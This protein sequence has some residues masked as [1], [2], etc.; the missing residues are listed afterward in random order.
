MA[1][2]QTAAAAETDASIV[3]WPLPRLLDH[4]VETYHA[5]LRTDLTRL[6]QLI[7]QRLATSSIEERVLLDEIERSLSVLRDELELHM[8]KEEQ[9][10][11]PWIR[12]GRGVSAKAP[13]KVM[14]REHQQTADL[15]AC[16]R[17]L[18]ARY[19]PAAGASAA[20]RS[21]AQGLAAIDDS[22]QAHM[23]LEELLFKR[24]LVA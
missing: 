1:P 7:Q 20:A 24:A 12:S 6:L 4:I 23:R 19:A 3:D 11:F 17:S 15:L 9:V 14:L 8:N 21:I 18:G 22:L 5:P 10:L 2:N 16:L 13:I